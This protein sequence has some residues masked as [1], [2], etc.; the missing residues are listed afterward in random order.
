MTG[1]AG[2]AGCSDQ[3]LASRMIEV[4]KHRGTGQ[5][6]FFHDEDV[7]LAVC[8]SEHSESSYG[9][10]DRHCAF[11]DGRIDNR[12]ELVSELERK[13][14]PLHVRSDPELLIRAHQQ[15][16]N[17]FASKLQGMFAFALWDGKSLLLGRDRL[18]GKPLFYANPRA[19]DLFLF[20]SEIKA[21]RQH[22]LE[23]SVNTHAFC[24]RK[25]IHHIIGTGSS[26]NEVH[27]VPPGHTMVV[28]EAGGGL[29]YRHVKNRVLEFLPVQD[30][31]ENQTVALLNAALL[32]TAER[33]V[34]K[35]PTSILLS[36]GMDST[37]LVSLLSRF[38]DAPVKTF[39]FADQEAYRD[40][41]F[42]RDVS[43]A[44]GTN[45]TEHI[46][47]PECVVSE[48][49]SIVAASE[50]LFGG[51]SF[52][53]Y[54]KEIK[55]RFPHI[56]TVF[57]GEGPDELFAGYRYF[58]D[59]QSYKQE[60]LGRL[61]D[62]GEIEE[63]LPIRNHIEEV[64]SRGLDSF[65]LDELSD[66]LTNSHLLFADHN[67][68][69]HGIEIRAP[70]LSEDVVELAT[71]IP[72]SLKISNGVTKYILRRVARELLP[73]ELMEVTRRPK[74]GAP[75]SVLNMIGRLRRL[76]ER[77]LTDKAAES[78]RYQAIADR[79]LNLL[80]LDL[81]EHLFVEN[82]GVVPRNFEISDLY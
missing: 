39:A 74:V 14:E 77:M 67:G 34:P 45:H 12:D 22:D 10:K 80:L 18:G 82:N 21:I 48:L 57:S 26:L 4:L 24:Q 60:L 17:A 43:A 23:V 5:P 66:Q 37:L 40:L 72:S 75:G 73:P 7:S 64:F 16:G 15:L 61:T 33:S 35:E 50:G 3:G 71:T 11:I 62:L 19:D 2:V 30:R 63:V 78:H 41:T 81:F 36:G 49:P 51:F 69:A 65:L 29:Q 76:S 1:L 54:S 31:D 38:S 25:L 58:K 59:P 28:E 55:S 52:Y 20:G 47:D 42:A 53:M 56:T 44:F 70:Y 68:M 27:Q 32:D 6:I 9:V 79:K 8:G 46:F 13:G